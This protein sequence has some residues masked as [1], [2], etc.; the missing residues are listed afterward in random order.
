MEEV[1]KESKTEI[2]KLIR[3]EVKIFELNWETCLITDWSKKRI[4]YSLMQMHCNCAPP[5]NPNCGGGHWKLVF[6]GSRFTT[7]AGL[8]THQLKGKPWLL[9]ID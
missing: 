4:G 3:E 2:V 7:A 8:D 5:L 6:A 1:F 9:Y